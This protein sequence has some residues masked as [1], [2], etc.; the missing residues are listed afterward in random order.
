MWDIFNG[1]LYER[2]WEEKTSSSLYFSM[3]HSLK[4]PCLFAFYLPNSPHHLT[5]MHSID[6][7]CVSPLSL[8]LPLCFL[9]LSKN[10]F[11]LE[12]RTLSDCSFDNKIERTS[13]LNSHS[14]FIIFP[15]TQKKKKKERKDSSWVMRDKRVLSKLK[16]NK[17]QERI[18]ARSG[19]FNY[20]NYNF[21]LWSTGR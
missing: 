21:K 20:D 11:S 7:P 18:S 5:L 1:C 10:L 17:K 8:P 9:F 15:H 13:V 16:N 2:V 14:V 3:R 6:L 4:L 12:S 19:Y